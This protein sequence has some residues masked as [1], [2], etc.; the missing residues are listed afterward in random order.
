MKTKPYAVAAIAFR[1]D[2]KFVLQQALVNAESEDVAIAMLV[3]KMAVELPEFK[4]SRSVAMRIVM[5][6]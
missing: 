4:H 3:G 2:D 1:D 5:E 6:K